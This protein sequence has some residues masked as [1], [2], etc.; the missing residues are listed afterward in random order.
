[1]LLVRLGEADRLVS[2]PGGEAEY[3]TS[4]RCGSSMPRAT[5][6]RTWRMRACPH[7]AASS[8]D[9]EARRVITDRSVWSVSR[10]Q[11]ALEPRE[12]IP[13]VAI[14][15]RHVARSLDHALEA[16]IVHEFLLTELNA[17]LG[18]NDPHRLRV[19]D[20]AGAVDDVHA[21]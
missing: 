14:D 2:H 13:D 17:A 4:R 16:C 3:A 12:E 15:S 19:R 18:L 5:W 20:L 10:A 7:V 8:P 9:G 6:R 11:M 1:M 21:M